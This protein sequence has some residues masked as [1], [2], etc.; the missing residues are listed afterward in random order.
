MEWITVAAG[1]NFARVNITYY[2]PKMVLI[3]LSTLDFQK[4][5]DQFFPQ[6]FNFCQPL[7]SSVEESAILDSSWDNS[8]SRC[9][10]I[11]VDLR[12]GTVC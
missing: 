12:S 9:C 1:I 3:I 7:R 11:M 10:G 6:F 5:L 2:E 4:Q 8:N